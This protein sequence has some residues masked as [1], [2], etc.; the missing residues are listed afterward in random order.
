MPEQPASGVRQNSG[1]ENLLADLVFEGGGVKG[2]GLAG[3]YRE[4]SDN[5]YQPGC[6]AGTSAGSIMASLVAAGYTGAELEDIVL[7][8]MD[9]TKFED[10]TFLHHFGTPGDIIEFAKSRGMHSGNYFLGWIRDLL[11][12]K[13]KTKFGHLRNPDTSD[14]KRAYK[15]QVIAS[16]LS[17]RSMLVL[18][19][20]ADDLGIDPDELEIAEAVRMSM[21]IPIFFKPVT[22]G[23]PRDRRRRTAVEFP[24]LAVRHSRRDR[25]PV[26]DVRAAPGSAGADRPAP[27]RAGTGDA[28]EADRVRHRLPRSDRGDDDGGPRPLLRRAGQLR[29]DDPDSHHRRAHDGV[30]HHSGARPG[31][32]RFGPGGSARLPG[33]LGLRP[34]Q[35]EVP[36]RDRRQSARDRGGTD[37]NRGPA[38]SAP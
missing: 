3:A 32:V 6:V 26:P 27:A 31:A 37:G 17:R 30:R 38:A 36:A 7:H 9:F 34:L 14:P 1:A 16:D 28:C 8:K 12:A 22:P 13:G 35:G 23:G 2:I 21:S 11:A 15:L 24:H 20:D 5:G 29:A 18:P 33:H 19:Q 25:T 10:G 4:L